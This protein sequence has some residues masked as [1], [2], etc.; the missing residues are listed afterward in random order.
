MGE[1]N[2]KL[3]VVVLTTKLP[4]DFWL[5]NKIADVCDIDGIV[6]PSGKRYREYGL[7][8]ILKNRIPRVGIGTVINQGLLVFYRL[9]FE[10]SKDKRQ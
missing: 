3:N 7:A 8:Y 4:E 10:R 2:K 1:T 6:L 5:V 9:I